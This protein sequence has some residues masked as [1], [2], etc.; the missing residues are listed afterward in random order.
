M[1]KNI[2]TFIAPILTGL[3]T[4]I[5]FCSCQQED[6][7]SPSLGPSTVSLNITLQYPE[8]VSFDSAYVV[9]KKDSTEEVKLILTLDNESHVATGYL[10]DLPCG[11]WKLSTSYFNT[12][13]TNHLSLEKNGV[14]TL[15]ISPTATD[16][17]STEAVVFI[18]EGVSPIHSKPF[19][20]ADY[21]YYQLFFDN[22][23]EGFVR[24]PA[25]P[26]NPYVEL[27]TF[28]ARWVYIYTDRSF[29][30]SSLDGISRYHLGTCAFETYGENGDNHDLLENHIVDTTSLEPGISK[31]RDKMWNFV[32]G[33]IIMYD[34]NDNEFF[35]YHVWDLRTSGGRIKSGI[36]PASPDRSAFVKKN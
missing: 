28:H 22:K 27:A 15:Q 13:R 1:N 30:N 23:L 34:N 5:F 26:T 24:L 4:L 20:W 16:L 32:D 11:D 9:F 14:V 8:R 10:A 25:D 19:K 17:I 36:R 2:K 3:G 6:N 12:I 29:Y 31:V 21:Y 35:L 33:V 7:L 18:K